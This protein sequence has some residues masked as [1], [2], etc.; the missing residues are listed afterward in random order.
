[1]PPLQRGQMKYA[2]V[3][4]IESICREQVVPFKCLRTPNKRDEDRG[5]IINATTQRFS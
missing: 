1:M 2:T 5:F 4:L 3:A